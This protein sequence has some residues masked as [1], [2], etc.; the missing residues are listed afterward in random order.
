MELAL[1]RLTE[2]YVAR[3]DFLP[4]ICVPGAY[5]SGTHNHISASNNK[6]LNKLIFI[7]PQP[8]DEC[9]SLTSLRRSKAGSNILHTSK[10]PTH[11]VRQEQMAVEVNLVYTK[12]RTLCLCQLQMAMRV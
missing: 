11:T 10:G 2:I 7:S 4:I 1:P 9:A 8:S 12:E 6:N 3:S 5:F